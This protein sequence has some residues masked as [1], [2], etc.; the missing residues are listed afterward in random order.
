MTP[1]EIV[2]AQFDAYNAQDVDAMCSYY[3]E[4]CT[5]VDF[6]GVAFIADRAA[7]HAHFTKVFAAHPKNRSWSADRMSVGNLVIDHE[8]NQRSPETP[9]TH[10][11]IVYTIRD[12]LIAHVVA[13]HPD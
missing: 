6:R 11:V 8:V 13:G 3:A 12:A 1:G 2:H 10:S 7:L 4:D 9:A 5:F